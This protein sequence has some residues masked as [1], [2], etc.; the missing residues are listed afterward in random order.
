MLGHGEMTGLDLGSHSAA[1]GPAI[2]AALSAAAPFC[3][4]TAPNP[5]VGASAID[6]QGNLLGSAAH[7]RAGRAH[8]EAALLERL[9]REG[10]LGQVHTLVVT[11]EPCNHTGRTPPCTEA[12]LRAQ[13]PRVVFLV[14]DPHPKAAGGGERLRA[15]GVEVLGAE[16]MRPVLS[17]EQRE[18]LVLQLGPFLKRVTQ[19]LPWITIK[20][21]LDPQGSMIPPPGTKTFTSESSLRFAHELRRRSDAILTGS[22]T[23]LADEPEFTVRKIPDHREKI[24]ALWIADRRARVGDAF[25]RDALSRRL[26]AERVPDWREA[27]TQA[28]S[29]GVLE[30]LVEAGPGLSAAVLQSQLWDRWVRFQVREGE[31]DTVLDEMAPVWKSSTL[32]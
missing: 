6:H 7:E 10:R 1:I 26:M 14:A 9:A 12:I 4:A 13:I 5:P 22:G 18:K 2:D 28:G 25:L 20:Q 29:L 17:V 8:A 30:V 21:A 31:P 19:G 11:L 32:I 24:R 16:Q 27:L 3:G 15:S 23:I